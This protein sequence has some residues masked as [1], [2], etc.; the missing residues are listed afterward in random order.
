VTDIP[1]LSSGERWTADEDERLYHAVVGLAARFP[2]RS[3]AA[4]LSRIALLQAA[5]WKRHNDSKRD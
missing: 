1:H 5:W 2:G 3:L 4:V